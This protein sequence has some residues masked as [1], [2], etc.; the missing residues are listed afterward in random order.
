MQLDRATELFPASAQDAFEA[1]GFA[2]LEARNNLVDT[3]TKLPS[4][5]WRTTRAQALEWIVQ[6]SAWTSLLRAVIKE[7]DDRRAYLEQDVPPSSAEDIVIYC[8]GGCEPNPGVGGW[9][10]VVYSG[11]W[12]AHAEHGGSL[13]ATNNTM[14]LMAALMA[15][16][17][18]S[19]NA[20]GRQARL[21]CD[22]QYVVKGCNEWRHK[23]KRNGWSRRGPNS[24]KP[25]AGIV[26][27]LDLWQ[28]LDEALEAV[29]IKLEWVKGHDGTVGNERADEL[30]A[31][32][33][34]EAIEAQGA[35]SLDSQYRAIMSR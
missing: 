19:E 20:N 30:A 25:E 21:L 11:M 33:R 23:W 4:N 24:P 15:L 31:I 18:I 16:R 26:A 5:C 1:Y 22:S 13:V 28:A 10:F 3:W 29:P 9:G 32:G 35:Q 8:D 34:A 27:N 7:V 14:E 2:E 12:E 17:W 6:G